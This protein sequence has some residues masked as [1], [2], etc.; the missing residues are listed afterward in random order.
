M[1][2]GIS[3]HEDVWEWRYISI[4]LDIGTR[5]RCVVSFKP[6]ALYPQKKASGTLWMRLG[7]S[8]SLLGIKHLPSAH[9]PSLTLKNTQFCQDC[10]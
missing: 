6:L 4:I 1:L 2:S 7:G 5:W 9:T 10:F 3:R 8:Q